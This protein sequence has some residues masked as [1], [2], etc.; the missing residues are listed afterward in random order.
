MPVWDAPHLTHPGILMKP[1]QLIIQ[2]VNKVAPVAKQIGQQ[3]SKL[4]TQATQTGSKFIGLK[5]PG[6]LVQGVGQLGLAFQ[7]VQMAV[8]AAM[9]I[10]GRFYDLLIGQNE[11]LNQ[12]VL[13]SAASIAATSRVF[14]DGMQLTDPTQT[15]KALQGPLLD[16]IK[17]VELDTMKLVGVTS[18][19]TT[20]VFNTILGNVGL[21][22]GQSKEFVS[23]IDSAVGLAP[24]LV[25]TLGTLG[26]DMGQA[27][28]EMRD[29]LQGTIG[30]DST[31][32]KSLGIT[33]QMVDDWK[34]Q[35]ILVDKLRE[36]FQPFVDANAIASES[37]MGYTSNIKDIIEIIGR[38]IGAPI[39]EK[40]VA[41]LKQ[42]Y[43]LLNENQEEIKAFAEAGVERF[44]QFVDVIEEFGPKFIEAFRPAAETLLP[45]IIDFASMLADGFQLL[46]PVAG[47]VAIALVPIVDFVAKLVKTTVEM[48]RTAQTGIGMLTGSY[49]RSTEAAENYLQQT[50]RILQEGV[51]AQWELKSAID[52]VSEARANGKTP[53]E[54]QLALAKQEL[55][56]TDRIIEGLKGQK[57]ELESALTITV[58]EEN[59]RNIQNQIDGL[60][61]QI[62]ALERTKEKAAEV[63]EI[64][65]DI[66]IESP[67]APD[68][69]DTLAQLNTQ[70][71]QAKTNLDK[72]QNTAG[73]DEA[74][75]KI[76]GLIQQQYEFGSLS[77][78]QA[79][80]QLAAIRDSGKVSAETQIAAQSEITKIQAEAGKARQQS[81][82]AE[83]SA[84]LITRQQYNQK[85]LDTTLAGLDAEL[86]E[87]QRRREKFG[88]DPEVLE[89]LALEEAD[90]N[91]RRTEA[92]KTFY[93]NQVK[94]IQESGQRQITILEGDF[95]RGLI[96][97]QAYYQQRRDLR[98]QSIDD[99]LA[100]IQQQKQRVGAGNKEAQEQL[101][102]Q[103]AELYGQRQD[104]LVQF[105]DEQLRLMERKQQEAT[106][107]LKLAEAERQTELQ[108]LINAGLLTD[109]EADQ[110]RL[111][112]KREQIEAEL[113]LEK[114][115]LAALEALPAYSDPQKEAER[116]AQ[117]RQSRIATAQLT[118]QLVENERAQQEA[119]VKVLE[120]QLNRVVQRIQNKMTA[121]QQQLERQQQIQEAI[122]QAMDQQNRLLDARKALQDAIT[123]AVTGDLQI[124]QEMAKTNRER[125]DLATLEAEI[126][127]R[128][129]RIN[130]EIELRNLEIQRQQNELAIERERIAI[131]MQ[132]A[133]NRSQIAQAQSELEVLQRTPGA[134]PE[135]VQ[136][137][138][139]ELQGL[140]D[141]GGFLGLQ[142]QLLD[143]R[144]EM[145]RRAA[146][147]EEMGIRER[148][149]S[150]R[151]QSRFEYGQTLQ[152][153][154]RREYLG[155]LRDEIYGRYRARPGDAESL[156]R[157]VDR[158]M[159]NRER[160]A[161][162][163]TNLP[164]FNPTLPQA[165]PQLNLP[166]PDSLPRSLDESR[167]L[168][169]LLNSVQ[170]ISQFVQ[171]LN[172]IANITQNNQIITQMNPGD[173][174]NGNLR[175]Q[176]EQ[177]IL[178][179]Q[180]TL[181]QKLQ[182]RSNR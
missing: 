69:G 120:E 75:K 3:L 178:D 161:D 150:E 60:D 39:A 151:T 53:T 113:D 14:Q 172:G 78:E 18:Q 143:R 9:S 135:R 55:E 132:Q 6:G 65:S 164:E 44:L 149:R 27:N 118:G 174:N 66:T 94:T 16:A 107:V 23:S 2:G 176:V 182:S 79:Q 21:L 52:A 112:L 148:Q 88:N 129:L 145:E 175:R 117:I 114:Q 127:L 74:A 166:I 89:K 141:Q 123:N 170:S 130:Q 83:L 67:L 25:A 42:V 106:D 37:V 76:Q 33:K 98:L 115:K 82:E 63:A 49:R 15:I 90:V 73:A 84:G 99:Q 8:D 59:R 160:R 57:G 116:Q 48:I 146:D 111:N 142:D 163:L 103:E 171:S 40:F 100:E 133:Q 34:A 137:K 4:A 147:M 41:G 58:G 156:G 92:T 20:Q 181:A 13:Q 31:I 125:R 50:D 157:G 95:S 72:A 56:Q 109:A 51:T 97:E 32:A 126:K 93:D 108:E 5:L 47:Q 136:A 87:I 153:S 68:L 81:L 101:A 128:S 179:T 144:A 86:A 167:V 70:L 140:V 121:Y 26:L 152:G 7:G 24:G 155:D 80:E 169:E 180:Y 85:T 17:Q 29:L 77:A 102:A 61:R 134:T 177:Q 28:Q 64:G 71:E 96:G 124:L 162:N 45:Q 30:P 138:Q 105:Q 165:S 122:S 154:D 1:V 19:Q 104:V 36:K 131:R 110:E 11:R 158:Y 91:R 173:V 46:V 43:Q 38:D 35:G 159:D 119:A 12:G 139:I 22:N 10:G 54:E 62:G 168:G